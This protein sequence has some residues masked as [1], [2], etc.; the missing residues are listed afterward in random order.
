MNPAYIFKLVSVTYPKQSE[1]IA[2]TQLFMHLTQAI[3]QM[4]K[5]KQSEQL[6]KVK[7]PARFMLSVLTFAQEELLEANQVQRVAQ[8][9]QGEQ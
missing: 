7:E 9:L 6:D 4:E 2:N 1:P 5:H 3:T 8:W